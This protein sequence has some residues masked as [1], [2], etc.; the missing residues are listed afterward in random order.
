V[1]VYGY[2]PSQPFAQIC[3]CFNKRQHKFLQFFVKISTGRNILLFIPNQDCRNV[4]TW[5]KS[6][7]SRK[8][9]RRETSLLRLSVQL[10]KALAHISG[11]MLHS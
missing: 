5:G 7:E 3:A 8:D 11:I 1:N 10:E 6:K 2:N 4:G 9:R